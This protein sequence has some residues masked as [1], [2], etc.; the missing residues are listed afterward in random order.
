MSKDIENY[1]ISR[2]RA[3]KAS[4]SYNGMLRRRKVASTLATLTV[5]IVS[6][7]FIQG[8]MMNPEIKN[9]GDLNNDGRS[10]LTVQMNQDLRQ[11]LE[12]VGIPT[13]ENTYLFLQQENGTYHRLDVVQA[14]E[15]AQ[16]LEEQE[17][18]K[19]RLEGKL[20]EEQ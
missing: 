9:A 4:K 11:Y 15:R 17:K 16:L 20:A 6:G 19:Q 8:Y 5:G 7:V 13:G 10:D 12:D 2:L 14:E 3:E 18:Q 1:E